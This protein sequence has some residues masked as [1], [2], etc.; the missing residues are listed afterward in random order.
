MKRR[1]SPQYAQYTKTEIP[2]WTREKCRI[3]TSWAR[4][5]MWEQELKPG[6]HTVNIISLCFE[7]VLQLRTR[8][9]INFFWGH[10]ESRNLPEFEKSLAELANSLLRYWSWLVATG[11]YLCSFALN[12][13]CFG[14]THLKALRKE[15][16]RTQ[17]L[18]KTLIQA[19]RQT[20]FE[21]FGAP[22]T[23]WS[24]TH[25]Q[26]IPLSQAAELFESKV[27]PSGGNKNWL[28]KEPL[29]S[30]GYHAMAP[31]C[32]NNCRESRK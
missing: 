7:L 17:L 3:E 22:L 28:K 8:E 32:P 19:N 10:V 21:L 27:P 30:N 26:G 4:T 11:R 2:K 1:C 9:T 13:L 15:N 24:Q 6:I 23:Q 12:S 20:C 5:T 31:L 29:F 16:E 18:W 14:Q 25:S